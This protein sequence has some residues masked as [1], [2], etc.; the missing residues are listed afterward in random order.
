MGVGTSRCT[1]RYILMKCTKGTQS[2]CRR[3]NCFFKGQTSFKTF[4][5]ENKILR[6]NQEDEIRLE[7]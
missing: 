7:S 1:L 2:M 4:K 3:P 5:E 6:K